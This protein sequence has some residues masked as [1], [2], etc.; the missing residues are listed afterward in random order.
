MT[1]ELKTG[2]ILQ[3]KKKYQENQDVDFYYCEGTDDDLTDDF[4]RAHL[5]ND[6][7]MSIEA[8]KEYEKNIKIAFGNDAICN[9]GYTNMMKHF[10]FVEVEHLDS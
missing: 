6:K 7:E 1:E 4:K 5:F 2:W 8:M 3:L 9:A 10:E